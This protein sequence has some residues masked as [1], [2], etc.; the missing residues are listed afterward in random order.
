MHSS[1]LR[2]V[3][4][5]ASVAIYF[6][7]KSFLGEK[8]GRFYSMGNTKFR[9]YRQT[10]QDGLYCS[11]LPFWVK[12]GPDPVYGGMRTCLDR[13][14]NTYSAEK[15]V[16]MQGG[17]GWMF[18]HRYNECKK[19]EEW[20]RISKNCINFIRKYCID[21]TDGRLYFVVS[22]DGVPFRK[23]RYVFSEYFYIIANAEYYKASKD[24]AYLNEARKY[25]KLVWD[26][27]DDPC[28]DPFKITPKFLDTAPAMR[29]LATELVMLLVTSTMRKCDPENTGEYLKSERLLIDTILKYHYNDKFGV[30]LENVSPLG[31][32]IG[33]LSSGRII[34]P[35]HCFETAWTLLSEAEDLKEPSLV[36]RV[37]KI[38]DGA[39]RYGWDRKYGGLLYFVDAEGYPLQAYEHDMKLWWVH[40]E[41]IIASIKLF[42]MTGEEKY[43]SDFEMLLDYALKHFNDDKY[44]EWYG[45]LRRDGVPT[46]PICKGNVFKGPFHVPRMY[47]EVLSELTNLEIA[48]K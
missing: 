37:E 48:F 32:Y 45:Y 28:K 16:W 13:E 1:D 39:F 36:A 20:L 41:A 43:F 29:G 33:T 46:E 17:G 34:N 5:D 26:I 30:L 38:Y 27:H 14:G 10:I 18:A 35:G 7:I 9:Q 15:S 40:T 23:R 4:S 31:E 8:E 6:D 44:G 25:Y 3:F 42:R 11:V 21:P 22:D 47:C 2:P 12:Y 24:E 19:E